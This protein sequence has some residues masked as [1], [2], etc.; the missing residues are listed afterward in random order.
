V[1]KILKYIP[2]FFLLLAGLAVSAHAI[3]PHDHHLSESSASH[4]DTCPFSNDKPDHHKGFPIHCHAFNDLASEKIVMSLV[5]LVDRHNYIAIATVFDPFAFSL[6]FQ[7]SSDSDYWE[8]I[9]EPSLL[10]FSPLRA[11]P[12]LS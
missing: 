4:D 3:I 7:S 1:R 2:G 8:L 10:E 6:R 11:P 5:P 9:P 12:S